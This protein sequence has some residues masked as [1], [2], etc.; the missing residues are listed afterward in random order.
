MNVSDCNAP[1][2]SKNYH[3]LPSQFH[4]VQ[5]GKGV[6]DGVEPLVVFFWQ[7][8]VKPKNPWQSNVTLA[9]GKPVICL[10]QRKNHKKIRIKMPRERLPQT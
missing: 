6:R 1:I 8:A 3:P 2:K 7:N 10:E 4:L 9:E 5:C